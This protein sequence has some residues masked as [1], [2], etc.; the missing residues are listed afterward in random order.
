[1]NKIIFD[2]GKSNLFTHL[3]PSSAHTPVRL[4]RCDLYSSTSSPLRSSEVMFMLLLD[5]EV[6]PL[7]GLSLIDNVS[8]VGELPRVVVVEELLPARR[9]FFA[10]CMRN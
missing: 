3:I 4:I 7:S 2:I 5:D 1:M 9:P 8:I 10:D 6:P